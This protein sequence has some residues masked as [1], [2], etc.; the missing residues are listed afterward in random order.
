MKNLLVGNMSFQMTE[1]DLND[2][3]KPFGQVT[4]VHLAMDREN[5]VAVTTGSTRECYQSIN[6]NG[7]SKLLY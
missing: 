5:S 3:F 2:L 7:K 4:R 1:A 6:K